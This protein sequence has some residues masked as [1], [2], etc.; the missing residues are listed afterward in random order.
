MAR[1]SSGVKAQQFVLTCLPRQRHIKCDETLPFC[2]HCTSTG[3]HCRN[4]FNEYAASATS[5]KRQ[6]STPT[7]REPS[8]SPAPSN[9]QATSRQWQIFDLFRSLT[10]KQVGGVL[11]KSSFWSVDV[12]RATEAYPVI[13]HSSL[14]MAAL[15]HQLRM[16]NAMNDFRKEYYEFALQESTTAI[17]ELRQL[18]MKPA[19]TYCDKE[20]ILLAN[21]L[22]T[23]I[24]CLQ[25]NL[26]QA[27]MHVRN[28]LHLFNEWHFSSETVAAARGATPQGVIDPRWLLHLI[29]YFEFQAHDIDATITAASWKRHS[30]ELLAPPVSGGFASV[31]DAYYEYMP[32]H[33]GFS[34]DPNASIDPK[35][36]ANEGRASGFETVY[37]RWRLRLQQLADD[38]D[39]G[40]PAQRRAVST[41]WLLVKC[42]RLCRHVRRSS[43]PNVWRTSNV[44]FREIVDSAEKL[45]QGEYGLAGDDSDAISPA[46][47]FSLSAVEALRLVGFVSRNGAI[48]RRVI[49]LLRT[50]QRRDGLWDSKLSSSLIEARMMLD[51]ATLQNLDDSKTCS[52]EDHVYMCKEHRALT[53]GG[54]MVGVK[55]F[56]TSINSRAGQRRGDQDLLVYTEWD[57]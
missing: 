20:A 19:L 33:Y 16:S 15:N 37:S 25:G 36:A 56:R 12:L 52:C 18:A 57:T 3:R 2:K 50:Y 23:G 49:A 30:Y 53:L 5:Q 48:R 40:S 35:S 7:S 45:L 42:E 11:S 4:N 22:F 38:P 55:M 47:T 54:E 24:A 28:A 41:L 39:E 34:V 9:I 10:V 46:F 26:Y 51:E 43:D 17:Q 31:A 8:K 29:S 44:E 27:L 14:A 32:L 13:F 6:W 21:V 1:Q